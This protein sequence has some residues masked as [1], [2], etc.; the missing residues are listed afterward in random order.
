MGV[1][2]LIIMSLVAFVLSF[3]QLM[4]K[5]FLLNNAYLYASEEERKRMD[6]NKELKKP[7]YRQ[8]GICFLLMGLGCVTNAAASVTSW[9]WLYILGGILIAVVL[10]Y[11]IVSSVL[12]NR[13]KGL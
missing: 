5:G 8:S 6:K 11:A 12:I 9:G 7:Y 1:I 4:E 10:I 2:I 13:R 3:F